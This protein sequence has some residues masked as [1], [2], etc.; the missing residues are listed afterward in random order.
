MKEKEKSRVILRL[1][2]YITV[3]PHGKGCKRNR[4]RGIRSWWG[5]AT[6]RM[7]WEGPQKGWGPNEL[8]K[9]HFK[10]EVSEGPWDRQCS[11]YH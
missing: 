2:V 9:G 7:V 3:Y 8:G 11:D 6:G 10:Q 5:R 1:G 4:I